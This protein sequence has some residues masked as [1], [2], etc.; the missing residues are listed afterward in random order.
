MGRKT[1]VVRASDPYVR[2]RFTVAHE[3][4][5]FLL[6][7]DRIGSSLT[8][9]EMYRSGLSRQEEVAA[10]SLAADILM[11]RPL[12]AEHIKKWGTDICVLARFFKVSD[13]A[14]R[15]RLGSK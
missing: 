3:I 1:K 10:N 4:A 5:R 7:W 13:A 8:D 15:T 2:R 6:Y 9:D 12:H 11:P 14:M